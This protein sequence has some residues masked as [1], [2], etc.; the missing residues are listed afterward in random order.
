M[1]F[2]LMSDDS[3]LPMREESKTPKRRRSNYNMYNQFKG[4]LILQSP[5]RLNQSISK[6]RRRSKNEGNMIKD[7]L[8]LHKFG[9]QRKKTRKI[10]VKPLQSNVD[11]SLM[12][13][14][15]HPIE[16]ASMIYYPDDK[17]TKKINTKLIELKK[18]TTKKTNLKRVENNLF[19]KLN[20]M[21]V[22]FQQIEGLN[23]INKT[24]D[25]DYFLNAKTCRTN[26]N[27]N[28]NILPSHRSS[29]NNLN[30]NNSYYVNRFRNNK[31]RSF[32]S[33]FNRQ[34]SNNS[35]MNSNIRSSI[36]APKQ[37]ETY[38]ISNSDKIKSEILP[39]HNDRSSLDFDKNHLKLTE[40]NRNSLNLRFSKKVSTQ[41]IN[42]NFLIKEKARNI[43]RIKPLYDSFDDDESDKDDEY[44]SNALLP[45]SPIIFF[46]DIFIFMSSLYTLFYIPLRMAQADCFCTDESK[47]NKII[48]Y[49]IDV[50][51][52]YDFC[53]S[54]FRGYYNYQLKL[55][56]NHS[57]IIMHYLKT[58]GIFDFIESIPIFSFSK[59][60]CAKNEETNYC[61]SYNMSTSL[62]IFEVLT[63]I[64]IMKIF[65]VRNK[66][67]N[68][69]F[70]FIL[71]LFS[72]NYALEKFLDN[73]FDF[74]FFLLAF[75]FFVCLNIFL[76]KQTYPNWI[77]T[78]N[79]QDRTLLYN[80]VTSSYS[81]IET[82]TTVGYGDVVCQNL[83]ERIFQ[84]FF[85]G[86][87]VIAYSYIIS[88]F[89][90]L[91][92]N[93]SQS[94]IKYNNSMKILEEIRV[95]YP[96]MPF[97]LYN[98]IYN[99]IESRNLAEKKLDANMLTNS[100]PFNLRNAL[101]LL[102]FDSCIKNFKFF[103]NCE[104]SNFIIQVLSKFVPA[105]NKKAEIIVYEGEMIE[106]IIIVKD[107]R[108][109]L[110]AAIDIDEPE[111]SIR[112]YFNV[113][114]QGITTAKEI[115]KLEEANKRLNNSQL[116][117]SKKT[118][119]FDNAKVVLNSV[120][121]KQVNF[122]LNSEFDDTSIL[123]K[124]SND[125]NK[126][127]NEKVHHLGT[128]FLKN[129]PIKNEQGNFKYIKIIDIRKNENYG[130][131]YMFMRRPSPLS[132]KVKSKFVELYLLPKKDVFSIAK[133][134]NNIWS[135]IHKK[136]FH[137]MLSIK[138]QTFNI[139]N[140]YIEIN[141][142][143]KISPNDVSRFVYAW[144]DPKKNKENKLND[145][146]YLF[147]S[148]KMQ[149]YLSPNPITINGN[150]NPNTTPLKI[151]PPNKSPI[152]R[153]ISP[154][155][156]TPINRANNDTSNNNINHLS[157]KSVEKASPEYRISQPI[158]TDMDFSYLLTVMAN[159]K[160]NPNNTINTNTNGNNVNN[161]NNIN[162]S[163]QNTNN[164]DMNLQ[165]NTSDLKDSSHSFVSNFFNEKKKTNYEEG[166]TIIMPQESGMLLPSTLNKIFDENK[167]DEI[168]EQM[169]KSK[170]KENI[171][172]ILSFGK[173]IAEL[174]T[175]KNYSL[176]LVDKNKDELVDLKNKSL[177]SSK[178]LIKENNDVLN[179]YLS[180]CQ[181]KLF[182]DKIHEMSFDEGNSIYQ[183][184]NAA[185]KQEEIISFSLES[186]YHNINTI[187]EMKYSKN[188]IY[189]EKTIK[190]LKK[191]MNKTVTSSK[192]SSNTSEY[193]S[194]SNSL[195]NEESSSY[196]SNIEKSKSISLNIS[197]Q[198][199]KNDILQLSND[200]KIESEFRS[201]KLYEKKKHK[202]NKHPKTKEK[203][204]S[205]GNSA[206]SKLDSDINIKKGGFNSIE[207]K[208]VLNLD[209]NKRINSS[210]KHK[211]NKNLRN[212]KKFTFKIDTI[213][214]DGSYN[215]KASSHHSKTNEKKNILYINK[216]KTSKMNSIKNSLFTT[217]DNNIRTVKGSKTAKRN[218]FGLAIDNNNKKSQLSDNKSVKIVKKDKT[219]KRKSVQV[220]PKGENNLLDLKSK[221]T[222]KDVIKNTMDYFSKEKKEDCKIQ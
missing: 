169:Q 111:E 150:A 149:N 57:K 63:N 69:T 114:F 119:D 220:N 23:D 83:I 182:L 50:L 161:P 139:L 53:I 172:K 113:N 87:G 134:Y 213:D 183:F 68:I 122:L 164:N 167:A 210:K 187:T 16:A 154:P 215:D 102:M 214:D 195:S 128:D 77:I 160:Q 37:N 125:Y 208:Q 112:N 153:N 206:F 204:Y 98:K 138:H 104:N 166:K 3:F 193:S 124:T 40:L 49:F 90:N 4:S 35:N 30:I 177:I 80:Y 217:N 141:G 6:L 199:N 178:T 59:Y 97:K 198:S 222:S 174:F 62:I 11:K 116:I 32:N 42:L 31:K 190:F 21:K 10:T 60:I 45:S 202:T 109:S 132:L 38:D 82:L 76:A 145:R 130:G 146:S 39:A 189:Q 137:N 106:E 170:K 58:D 73:L 123:D 209:S 117:K 192:S 13:N 81:L 95:D 61:F 2:H 120:V 196:N 107:G 36:F 67:K 56:K 108:L 43:S 75:H 64:K 127:E 89:G 144:E 180:L 85:L 110:E 155:N 159:G 66:Q 147:F 219:S 12:F 93:E 133:N 165:M 184:D 135:K 1:S 131:L 126:K 52:I 9:I 54:F 142:I 20:N 156:I 129:E 205:I 207:P 8:H 71:D 151:S 194:F 14:N 181:N 176:I 157:N 175:N 152:N 103:K 44:S 78:I 148:N 185:L 163:I 22:N 92:K 18:E 65:K 46:L 201:E 79:T 55:I 51:Y 7:Y 19:Q 158:A 17:N 99:Y 94:S 115:K 105:V 47:F 100:L 191:L 28:N 41:S 197:A 70:N 179:N 29:K 171:K 218:F 200:S 168:K 34:N 203:K 88:S 48:L 221:R 140:K 5:L 33:G 15:S 27:I 96:N 25:D 74:S 186:L 211:I 188:K 173:K 118:R 24:Y 84:I 26:N 72:E 143:G 91:I 136:D 101:L 212:N 86:V 121:K 162:N 216:K